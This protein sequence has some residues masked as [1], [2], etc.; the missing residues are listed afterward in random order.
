MS[1]KL[2]ITAQKM[3]QAIARDDAAAGCSEEGVA[4]DMVGWVAD[5]N[6]WSSLTALRHGAAGCR[7]CVARFGAA[8]F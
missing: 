2:S 1:P 7:R 5:L 4:K 8:G 6:E 3:S